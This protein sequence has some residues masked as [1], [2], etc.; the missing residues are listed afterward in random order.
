MSENKE[1]M[2]HL[3]IR[4]TEYEKNELDKY[5]NGYGQRTTIVRALL[6]KFFNDMKDKETTNENSPTN[7]TKKC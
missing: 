3:N 6:R 7:G 2:Y 5:C 4:L 1:K